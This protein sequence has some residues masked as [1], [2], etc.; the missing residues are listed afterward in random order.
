MRSEN[1][2][3]KRKHFSYIYKNG[4][5]KFS[6]TLQLVFIKSKLKPFKVGFSVSKKIGKSVV[7]NKVK[8]RLK[9]AF[10]A[11]QNNINQDYNYILVAREGI[12]KLDFSQ[13]KQE[14]VS[15]LKKA[16][17]YVETNN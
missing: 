17:L 12:E 14:V 15:V 6:P 2:L 9:E 10:F 5:S 3:K 16:N 4:E 11:L 1:R 8:R 7:R 13:I